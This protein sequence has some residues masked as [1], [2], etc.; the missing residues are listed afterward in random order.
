MALHL[1]LFL[2]IFSWTLADVSAQFEANVYKYTGCIDDCSNSECPSGH[3]VY[4]NYWVQFGATDSYGQSYSMCGWA[5]QERC[6]CH[7]CSAGYFD[8][9]TDCAACPIG[10]YTSSVASTSCSTCPSGQRTNAASAATGCV[11]CPA[12]KYALLD[13]CNDCTAGTYSSAESSTCSACST[14]K[15]SQGGAASCTA[16]TAG[17][18]AL[19]TRTPCADCSAG[20]Y[21][22]AEAALCTP[23]ANGKYSGA[24]ASSCDDCA[25]GTYAAGAA[26]E[27]TSCSAGTYSNTAS[28]LCTPCS[29]GRYSSAA[30]ATC[31]ECPAG[32]YSL[33]ATEACSNCPAGAYSTSSAAACFPCGSGTWSEPGSG[34]CTACAQ[35]KYRL[36]QP[37]GCSDCPGGT[38]TSDVGRSSCSLCGVGRYAGTAA[39]TCTDC[40]AGKYSTGAAETCS[41]CPGGKYSSSEAAS[42]CSTCGRGEYSTGGASSCAACD[43]GKWSVGDS[44]SCYE[45]ADNFENCPVHPVSDHLVDNECNYLYQNDWKTVAEEGASPFGNTCGSLAMCQHESSATEDDYYI[46][47]AECADG[48]IPLGVNSGSESVRGACSSQGHYPVACVSPT[49]LA[50][51]PQEEDGLTARDHDCKYFYNGD[52][53]EKDGGEQTPFTTCASYSVCDATYGSN[54]GMKNE[55]HIFCAACPDNYK[56]FMEDSGSDQPGTCGN[57]AAISSCYSANE[58]ATCPSYATGGCTYLGPGTFGGSRSPE[59]TA[60]SS[61]VCKEYE[62]I[63]KSTDS[64]TGLISYDV[65]CTECKDGL[66][67]G[68]YFTH[69]TGRTLLGSCYDAPDA[70]SDQSSYKSC[71]ADDAHGKTVKCNYLSSSGE[72]GAEQW[73]GVGYGEN[74][75]Q[76]LYAGCTSFTLCSYATTETNTT[77]N[78]MCSACKPDHV[79]TYNTEAGV[80]GACSSSGTF[81]TKCVYTGV[82]TESPTAAPTPARTPS[83]TIAPTPTPTPPVNHVENTLIWMSNFV[84]AHFELFLGLLALVIILL[85]MGAYKCYHN[86]KY[87]DR[88]DSDGER[89]DSMWSFDA[90]DVDRVMER[91]ASQRTGATGGGASYRN[92]MSQEL[93]LMNSGSRSVNSNHHRELQEEWVERM[94]PNGVKYFENTRTRRAT[95]TDRR[96]GGDGGLGVPEGPGSMSIRN[97]G[98][99]SGSSRRG[100][101]GVNQSR[102]GSAMNVSLSGVREDVASSTASSSNRFEW[103]DNPM[104]DEEGGG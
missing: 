94:D 54:G 28:T 23:C 53:V 8:S 42:S 69:S 15:Y 4:D 20:K 72:D 101:A 56:S 95:W 87:R 27:C 100:S 19:D 44:S 78:F 104:R 30:A 11:V 47:C 34:S 58:F 89:G 45:L 76:N 92:G 103:N 79:S 86:D 62:I 66:E 39:T 37:D 59:M 77:M 73:S 50:T 64:I 70:G 31:S 36:A 18:Y 93:P 67:A 55:F 43:D 25:A 68:D 90:R 75:P 9:L 65:A 5:W 38:Y 81:P 57:L 7:G 26:S 21:A 74:A 32:T 82:T 51:C 16:C 40:T 84:S 3:R 102:R 22:E 48:L 2:A 49:S 91:Q 88:Y 24:A 6:R 1:L 80:E 14:G 52:W 85:G 60:P 12:G 29:A 10:S 13:Q 96:E 41:D 46:A 33:G 97:A 63:S 98:S 61:G 17:R 83:P 99:G 35:G 71:T